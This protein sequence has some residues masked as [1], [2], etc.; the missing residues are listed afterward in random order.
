ME[1]KIN[2]EEFFNTDDKI[3]CFDDLERANV[4]VI[5]IFRVHK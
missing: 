2:Y 4:D 3:L 5:D 1:T